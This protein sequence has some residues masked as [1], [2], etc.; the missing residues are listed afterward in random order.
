MATLVM[1][2][3]IEE[4]L[5]EKRRAWGGDRYDEVWDGVYIMSP[6]ANVEH[7]RVVSGLTI[8]LGAALAGKAEVFAGINVTNRSDDWKQNYRC[9]DLSVVF[10]GS[11][12]VDCGPYFLGGPDFIVE[13]A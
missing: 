11:K 10:P 13:V 5:L 9:P 3:H 12:A 1:D 8:A 6:L 4:E 2:P 7:Q